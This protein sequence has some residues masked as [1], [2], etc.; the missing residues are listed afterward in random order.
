[1]LEVIRDPD[2]LALLADAWNRLA[3][4]FRTPLLQN[5]WLSSCARAF[6]RPGQLYVF[7]INTAAGISAAAPL[8]LVR[9]R[10]IKRF[11]F[12]GSRELGEPCGLIYQDKESLK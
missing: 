11:E 5:D 3:E 1:M 7:I 12:L 10:F 2:A 6:C 8:V 4:P 9:N